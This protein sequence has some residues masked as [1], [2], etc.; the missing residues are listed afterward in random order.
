MAASL[1]ACMLASALHYRLPPRILPAIQRVEGGTM[2]HVSTNTDGSVDIGLMQIN[3]RWI[4]PIASMIHQPVPQVAARLALDPCFN[5]AAAAMILRRALDDEHGNLMKAIG[6]YHSRTLPLNLD[7]QR[8]VVAA[9]A[10]LYL[11]QG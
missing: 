2:G 7:Y 10:A 11:R 8:K 3:S 6:D 5:I 1:L 4:L 9:A